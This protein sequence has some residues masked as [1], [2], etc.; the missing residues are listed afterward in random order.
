MGNKN[1]GA[2]APKVQ[3]KKEPVKVD[4]K[5][6][7]DT[8]TKVVTPGTNTK[9]EDTKP[10]SGV[11]SSGKVEVKEVEE[12]QSFQ[13]KLLHPY[14]AKTLDE[15][16][17]DSFS[18]MDANH[19]A[20]LLHAATEFYKS[21][22]PHAPSTMFAKD[23]LD[24]N[25]QYALVRVSVQNWQ[26]GKGNGLN[27]PTSLVEHYVGAFNAF[28]MAL[29]PSKTSSDG[30]QTEL[31]FDGEASD[32]E[33]VEEVKKDNETAQ[34]IERKEIIVELDPDKWESDEEAVK[35]LA[36]QISQPGP[37][38]ENFYIMIDKAKTYLL[39]NADAKK[40]EEYGDYTIGD[41]FKAA[42]SLMGKKSILFS[43]G[44][45]STVV[46]SMKGDHNVVFSHCMVKLAMPKLNEE[47][48]RD[49]I[50]S[51]VFV[52]NSETNVPI[53]QDLA[54]KNGIT[55]VT[56]EDLLGLATDLT[57]ISRKVLAKLKALYK[58][59]FGKPLEDAYTRNVVNKMIDITNMYLEKDSVLSHY[60][61]K[62]YPEAYK[63]VVDKIAEEEGTIKKPETAAE[64]EKS[65]K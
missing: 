8:T 1:K 36:A 34:K 59:E 41:W 25:F 38:G 10:K 48:T 51:F 24:F 40:T 57:P 31:V 27:V 23:M 17:F 50:K 52:R 19:Q 9:K 16:K 26:E 3:D 64:K 37:A 42:M 14:V 5:E 39:K 56:R 30:K 43:R 47:E 4:N 2:K 54:V 33:A 32:K 11:D 18:A 55:N 21:R 62:E 63:A 35:G 46:S 53:D 15:M 61:E 65:T 58:D 12:V 6:K 45:V 44:M 29:N 13:D 20:I 60:E 22:D 49:L 7:K 28:G